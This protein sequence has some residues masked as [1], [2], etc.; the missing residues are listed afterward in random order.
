MDRLFT[1]TG[2]DSYLSQDFF[3]PIELDKTDSYALGLYSFNVFNS[4]PNVQL[5]KNDLFHFRVMADVGGKQAANFVITIPEGAY[6]IDAIEKFIYEAT[7]DK[8][9]EILK[10]AFVA[11]KF[12]FS[13]K[14]NVCTQQ[15][16][17]FASFPIDF[18]KKNSIG[19]LL[20]FEN[21]MINAEIES[22]SNSIV[23]ITAVDVVNIECNI[24]CGSYINGE[25]SHTLYSFNPNDVPPGYKIS[26]RPANVLYLPVNSN[27][28]S[29][30]TLRLVDQ[31]RNIVNFRGEHIVVQLNLRKFN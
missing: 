5:G 14:P 8:H 7:L 29:N 4:I 12:H 19:N 20:G 11:D 30:I 28:I 9:K 31:E 23:K 6:E 15:I 18:K 22:S 26:L 10:D 2:F 3:P 13:L 24:V 27:Y 21:V 1:I 17:I 25:P 16:V